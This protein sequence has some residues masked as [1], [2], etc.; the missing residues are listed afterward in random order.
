MTESTIPFPPPISDPS[1]EMRREVA[2]LIFDTARMM[3]RSMESHVRSA[4]VN[5]SQWRVLLQVARQNGQTQS[6]LA[7]EV[8]IAPAPLG[9]LLDRLEEQKFI[10]RR[11]D[12]SDRRVKRVYFTGNEQGRFFDRLRQL[13]LAHFEKVYSTLD[14]RDVLELQ[15]LLQKIK[16]NMTAGP[17]AQP[18]VPVKNNNIVS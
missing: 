1:F 15:R 16:S 14:D 3:T 18:A 2:W 12:P 6:H 17:P 11:P 5:S 9:R 13:A 10:E 7:E 4:G 8:E